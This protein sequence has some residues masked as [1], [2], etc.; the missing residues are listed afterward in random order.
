MKGAMEYL[1]PEVIAKLNNSITGEIKTD[2]VT[3]V[4]YST[5]ASIHKIEPMGVVFPRNTDEL[6][7]IGQ[8]CNQYKIPIIARGS[9]SGLA[10]QS[11]GKGLIIDCSRHINKLVSINPEDQTATVEPGLIL[12]DLNRAA[13][14]YSLQFGPDPASS[15]RATLGGCIGNNAA[16]AHS[17]LYGMTADH[18]H[19]AEVVLSDGSITTFKPVTMEAAHQIADGA[20]CW[21]NNRSGRVGRATIAVIGMGR[22]GFFPKKLGI[23]RMLF[24]LGFTGAC[25][26]SPLTTRGR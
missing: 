22:A 13:K 10:G 20:V 12:D 8:I 26:T 23:P 11:I 2:Q 1:L 18:I 3:R 24:R 9:G 19:S 6:I 5:D 7:T 16:G 17:I 15:E 14:K 25:S 4:L 21:Y